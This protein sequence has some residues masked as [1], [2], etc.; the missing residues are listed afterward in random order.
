MLNFENAIAYFAKYGGAS[1]CEAELKA[2]F[3]TSTMAQMRAAVDH[4]ITIER[5][6]EIEVHLHLL[7]LF[8]PMT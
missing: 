4:A 8:G 3:L 5:R 2:K 7:S 1:T 6:P